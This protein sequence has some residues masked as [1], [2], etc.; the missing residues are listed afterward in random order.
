MF[1]VVLNSCSTCRLRIATAAPLIIDNYVHAYQ[2]VMTVFA[3][4]YKQMP[5]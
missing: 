4:D 1:T 5:Y 2:M 3:V